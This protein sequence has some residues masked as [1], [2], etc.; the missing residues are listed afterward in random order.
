MRESARFFAP[1]L[2]PWNCSRSRPGGNHVEDEFAPWISLRIGGRGF[3]AGQPGVGCRVFHI[4]TGRGATRIAGSVTNSGVE[5]RP[6][7]YWRSN[8]S[9]QGRL[10]CVRRTLPGKSVLE[11]PALTPPTYRGWVFGYSSGLGFG[12]LHNAAREGTL[13]GLAL[14]RVRP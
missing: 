10:Q 3:V 14:H 5:R 8:W 13:K 9:N 6:A 2:L 12:W 4:E 1:A 7:R 11:L